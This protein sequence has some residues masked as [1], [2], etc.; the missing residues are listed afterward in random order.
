M[1]GIHG[2]TPATEWIWIRRHIDRLLIFPVQLSW[3]TDIGWNKR[4]W[5]KVKQSNSRRALLN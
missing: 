3:D 2:E 5:Q 1:G 4:T